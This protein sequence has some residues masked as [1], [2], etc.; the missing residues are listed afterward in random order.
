MGEKDGRHCLK[1]L[2]RQ[3]EIDGRVDT[4]DRGLLINDK[5]PQIPDT[6]RSCISE[7]VDAREVVLLALRHGRILE[8]MTSIN[9]DVLVTSLLDDGKHRPHKR[10]HAA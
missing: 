9:N 7:L 1:Q 4:G 10:F 2:L 6:R 3:P 5:R 8:R